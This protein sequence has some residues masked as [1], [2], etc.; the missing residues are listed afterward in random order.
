MQHGRRV[1]EREI[2]DYE[3]DDIDGGEYVE[4]NNDFQCI[5]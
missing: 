3:Y 5:R 1:G 2:D 4:D